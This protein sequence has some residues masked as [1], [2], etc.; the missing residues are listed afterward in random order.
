MKVRVLD[1]SLGYA[2]FYRL[3]RLALEIE[4]FDGQ[5]SKPM[6]REVVERSDVDF[7]PLMLVIATWRT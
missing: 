3:R 4:R 2:G 1:N 6:V 7:T 5:F